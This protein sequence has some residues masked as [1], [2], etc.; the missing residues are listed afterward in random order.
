M[1]RAETNAG[2]PLRVTLGI[3]SNGV[4]ALSKSVPKLDSLIT[5]SRNNLT[6][7]HREGNR[8]DILGVS[9]EATG[10]AA[11]VDLP[12]TES[13]VPGSRE[14]ELS[15]RGDDNITDEVGVSPQGTLSISVGVVITT[16]V[17]EAP[18]E[19]RLVAR[20]GENEVGVL[21]G[22]GDGGH[23]VVVALEG[24]AEAKSFG[25]GCLV[26]VRRC[27]VRVVGVGGWEACQQG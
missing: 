8:E 20:S 26:R 25:H 11:R 18:D 17:G 5:G 9:N 13:S 6:V 2:N 12:K 10:G 27:R 24:S 14:C 22:G 21:R 7:V 3:S 23:P 19:D 16:R 1:A 15:I 4:F